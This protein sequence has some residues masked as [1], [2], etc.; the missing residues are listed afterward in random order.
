MLQVF[1]GGSK[2]SLTTLSIMC[3]EYIYSMR[4]HVS[5][6][7]ALVGLQVSGLYVFW[8]SRRV[9]ILVR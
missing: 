1:L 6:T 4:V 2:N 9:W 5:F 8:S 3:L 7:I